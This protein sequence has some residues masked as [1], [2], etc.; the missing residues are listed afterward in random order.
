MFGCEVLII[1]RKL[2]MVVVYSRD[3]TKKEKKYC[4]FRVIKAYEART[5]LRDSVSQCSTRVGVRLV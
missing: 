4:D 5:P 3:T 1:L 2:D